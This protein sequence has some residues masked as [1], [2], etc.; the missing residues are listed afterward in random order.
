[1]SEIAIAQTI[2]DFISNLAVPAQIIVFVVVGVVLIHNTAN[3][4]LY[5]VARR[6]KTT[7]I[8]MRFCEDILNNIVN[9]STENAM[10]IMTGYG[11]GAMTQEDRLELLA[12]NLAS[13]DTLLHRIK[14]DIKGIVID[15]GYFKL[16]KAGKFDDIKELVELR[17]KQ[18]RGTAQAGVSPIFRPNSP[19]IGLSEKRFPMVASINLMDAIVDKHIKEMYLEEADIRSCGFRNFLWL[20]KFFKYNHKDWDDALRL[21]K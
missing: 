10:G 13:T 3:Y 5:M 17:A 14:H 9:T 6:Q 16:H 21:R 11:G 15:N 19:L 8:V 4:M 1:M 18:L 20:Y 2:I 7:Q 12:Y